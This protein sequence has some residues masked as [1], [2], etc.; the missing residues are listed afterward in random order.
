MNKPMR[1]IWRLMPLLI[2]LSTGGLSACAPQAASAVPVWSGIAQTGSSAFQRATGPVEFDFPTDLGAHADFQTEWWYLTGNLE[3]DEGRR[4]GYQLTFFRRALQPAAERSARSSA[5]AAEQVYLAHFTVSDITNEQFYQTEKL[6]RGAAGLAGA[7]GTP[8]FSVWL[9]DWRVEQ[10][11][12]GTFSLSAEG[13]GYAL[14]L[15]LSAQKELVLQGD[16][17][18]SQKGAEIGNA[19]Y[20]TSYTRLKSQGEVTIGAEVYP[21]SGLSWMDHE[22]STSALG[23]GEVGWDWFSLQLDDGAELMLFTI[24]D[25]AGQVSAYSSGAYVAADSSQ[26]RLTRA[27]FEVQSGKTWTSPHTGAVYPAGWTVTVPELEIALTIEPLMA[28]QE[29]RLSFNYWEGAVR[30][31]G[32]A[33]GGSVQGYGYVELTGYGQSLENAF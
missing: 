1:Q 12:D 15:Q 11:L 5:W 32:S 18:Y 9:D 31:T 25:Q 13:D 26:Y 24:R 16:Q 3:T 27:D 28:D 6:S 10:A 30:I 20:Y 14:K 19:S 29:L 21:V 8:N 4:F 33:N 22:Y 2:L 7:A 17:G 23:V